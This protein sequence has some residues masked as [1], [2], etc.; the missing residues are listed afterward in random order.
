MRRLPSLGRL[1]HTPL[2]GLIMLALL[3]LLGAGLVGCDQQAAADATQDGRLQIQVVGN[4]LVRHSPIGTEE[5]PGTF[6]FASGTTVQLTAT[7]D[8][9]G[10]LFSHW[11]GDVTGSA[12]PLSIGLRGSV[13]VT[14]HFVQDL[15]QPVGDFT[16]GPSAPD[17]L[18]PV[19]ITFRDASTNNPTSWEWQFGDGATSTVQNPS[20][21]YTRAGI[22]DVTLTPSNPAY[23]GVPI[24]EQA[25]VVVTDEV[26]GSPY[27]Y[28]QDDPSQPLASHTSQEATW[29]QEVLRL[30]NQERANAGL[31]PVRW[32]AEATKAAK[33]H[34]EDMAGRTYFSHDTP[35]GWGPGDRVRI[36]GARTSWSGENI[37]RGYSSPAA[38]MTAWMNSSGHR[39]NIL[40]ASSTGL[41]VGVRA[42]GR[43][44][45]QVFSR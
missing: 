38:V 22:F 26:S 8:G 13:T 31:N 12:N 39:A 4:G 34:A 2:V 42:Q 1:W 27:W 37:A 33:A 15:G 41:G 11:S 44:W 24:T 7:P 36:I 3:P 9:A 30:V 45:V 18:A 6:V 17:G 5:S 29:A 20:H 10:W 23:T 28:E 40:R 19:T 14:A 43:Y 21:T 16:Y 35:E 25:L 32:D